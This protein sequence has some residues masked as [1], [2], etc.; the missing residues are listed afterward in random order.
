MRRQRLEIPPG[1]SAYRLR[2]AARGAI[3]A[4]IASA[5]WGL[6]PGWPHEADV[7]EYPL[8]NNGGTSGLNNNQ[9]NTNYHY[10]DSNNNAAAGAGVVSPSG[11]LAGTW[12]TFGMDWTTGTSV[13]FY[14]DG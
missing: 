3:T 8:T 9:S 12:H 5:V 14:L 2:C 1:S 10:T 6:Y 13:T 11:S 7:M 4:A